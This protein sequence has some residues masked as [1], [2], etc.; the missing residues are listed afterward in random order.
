MR[1]NV[2]DNEGKLEEKNIGEKMKGKV[3]LTRS[4]NDKSLN[5]KGKKIAE[6]TSE[7]KRKSEPGL[8]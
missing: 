6:E 1:K 7:K 2:E 8:D 3:H 4:G 5:E